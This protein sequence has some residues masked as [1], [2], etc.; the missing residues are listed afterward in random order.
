[1][2]TLLVIPAFAFGVQAHASDFL[3]VVR[4]TDAVVVSVTVQCPGESDLV[5]LLQYEERLP[6]SATYRVVGGLPP[7]TLVADEADKN[8]NV[9][10]TVVDAT[11]RESRGCGVIGELRTTRVEGCNGSRSNGIPGGGPA[12]GEIPAAPLVANEAEENPSED[13]PRVVRRTAS[14]PDPDGGGRPIVREER[15]KDVRPP[16]PAPR[17]QKQDVLRPGGT[18]PQPSPRLTTSY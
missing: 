9:C 17:P 16:T 2:R 12:P 3:V 18:T 4:T 15:S 10:F 14:R 11:G 1:M 7:F 8:G 5:P 13:R 6:G